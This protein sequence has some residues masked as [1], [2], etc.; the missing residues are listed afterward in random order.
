MRRP[1]RNQTWT[2]SYRILLVVLPLVAALTIAPGCSS[3]DN[4]D[5][6]AI[7]SS[8]SS[9]QPTS[10]SGDLSAAELEHGIGPVKAFEP[11]PIDDALAATGDELFRLKCS[12]C[13]KVEERYI[14]PALG[15]VTTKRSPAYIMNMILN[16]VEM[17]QRH[18][19]ARALLA[20]YAAPMADQSLSEEE[21]RAL[22]EYLRSVAQ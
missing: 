13:H 9:S 2:F 17:T 16:P 14:G 21:A 6:P 18:P 12:A 22:L 4:N 19:E 8:G 15:D 11:G 7:T 3:P 1:A 20:E 10:T 5:T